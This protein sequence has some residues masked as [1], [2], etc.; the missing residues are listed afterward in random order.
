MKTW[1]QV[2]LNKKRYNKR[3]LRNDQKKKD[4]KGQ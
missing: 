2:D 3:Y 4:K 1:K